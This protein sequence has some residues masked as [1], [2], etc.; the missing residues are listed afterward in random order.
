MTCRF[1]DL[2]RRIV[3]LFFYI[4]DDVLGISSDRKIAGSI[5]RVRTYHLSNQPRTRTAVLRRWLACHA[6]AG[7]S[8]ATEPSRLV[9]DVSGWTQT[10]SIPNRG[11]SLPSSGGM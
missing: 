2:I 7:N 1:D 6:G 3:K 11:G 4:S 9:Q 5:C 10:V 8:N